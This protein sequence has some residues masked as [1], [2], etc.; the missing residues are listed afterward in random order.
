MDIIQKTCFS[1][2]RHK[3]FGET[4]SSEL[5]QYIGSTRWALPSRNFNSLLFFSHFSTEFGVWHFKWTG[6]GVGVEFWAPLF[7][8]LQCSFTDQHI[9][10]HIL[11]GSGVLNLRVFYLCVK[12][13]VHLLSL[14]YLFIYCVFSQLLNSLYLQVSA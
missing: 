7:F 12:P 5:C 6:V 3:Q 11:C 2:L 10:T 8:Q 4:H 1:T 9:H 13:F 14:I